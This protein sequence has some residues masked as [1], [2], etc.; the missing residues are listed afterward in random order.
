MDFIGI[1]VKRV[2]D[3]PQH[4]SCARRNPRMGARIANSRHQNCLG[5]PSVA[6]PCNYCLARF[7]PNIDI[8][9]YGFIY[10]AI[11]YFGI[12]FKDIGHFHPEIHEVLN[13]SGTFSYFPAITRP[14][15]VGIEDHICVFSHIVDAIDIGCNVKC[16]EI[17]SFGRYH[18]RP[19]KRQA[20]NI[21]AF[22]DKIIGCG[23]RVDIVRIHNPRD[24]ST[25]CSCLVY[26]C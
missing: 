4:F 24:C 2:L 14:I 15:V 3:I 23:F 7:P 8:V 11:N 6:N 18:A 22:V 12:G 17:C 25:L 1:V 10:Q 16:A 5:S 26:T 13:G 9:I 20:K 19:T 21:H